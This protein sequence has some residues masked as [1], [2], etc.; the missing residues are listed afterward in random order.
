[1]YLD[2]LK[3]IKYF[4]YIFYIFTGITVDKIVFT[5]NCLKIRNGQKLGF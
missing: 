2:G 5:S 3:H 1:M 4:T